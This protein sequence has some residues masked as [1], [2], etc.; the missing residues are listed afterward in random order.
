MLYGSTMNFNG[1]QGETAAFLTDKPTTRRLDTCVT[2][3]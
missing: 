2:P 1:A 3:V